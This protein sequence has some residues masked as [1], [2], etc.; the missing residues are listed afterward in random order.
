MDGASKGFPPPLQLF[1]VKQEGVETGVTLK[2]TCPL[3]G[4]NLPEPAG[5]GK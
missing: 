3:A 2:G 4:Q 1:H 5:L